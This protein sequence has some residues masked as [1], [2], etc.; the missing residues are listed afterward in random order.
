MAGPDHTTPQSGNVAPRNRLHYPSDCEITQGL[1]QRSLER[2]G[3]PERSYAWKNCLPQAAGIK[4]LLL[5]VD[6]VLTDS[7]IVY[8]P[9]GY[10][11]KSFSTRDG[12]GIRLL[13]EAGVETGLITARTS[14]TVRRRAED[15]QLRHVYQGRGAK[16]EV[17]QQVLAAEKLAP[18]QVAYV[19]DDWLDL[20]LLLRAG[21]A[22]AV[23]DAVAEVRAAAHYVTRAAGGRGAVR[24]VC[25]LII[26]ARGMRDKLL[27]DYAR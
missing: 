7:T 2:A 24:E 15:L 1:R 8:G 26:E 25:E 22:V 20:P 21:L 11:M 23:A 17:W 4:L 16:L 13:R 14:E 18:E 19:G 12:L 9:E 27:A 6:G 3:G 10:E 5:D